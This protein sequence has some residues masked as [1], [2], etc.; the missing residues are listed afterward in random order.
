MPGLL[1][2]STSHAR[3]LVERDE[4]VGYHLEQGGPLSGRA[5]AARCG[6]CGTGR[7]ATCRCRQTCGRPPG[8]PGCACACIP[9]G[10]PLAPTPPRPCARARGGVVHARC[11]WALGGRSRGCG[12][13]TRRVPRAI[14]RAPC[15]LAPRGSFYASTAATARP[16]SRSPRSFA[17]GIATGG[18]A[19]RSSAGQA[20]V[21]AA[22]LLR[23]RANAER[24]G[25]P[26]PPSR[27]S[28]TPGWPPTPLRIRRGSTGAHPRPASGRLGTARIRTDPAKGFPPGASDF[29]RATLLRCSAASKKHGHSR[30]HDPST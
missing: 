23:E 1:T 9:S 5:R 12:R 26:K 11:R 24:R 13:R 25:T 3:S 16:A 6:R 28:A 8:L 18:G 17:G 27:S 20:A 14:P 15:L 29:G 2:G 10:R 7:A 4:V 30:R 21:R 22:R 19:W